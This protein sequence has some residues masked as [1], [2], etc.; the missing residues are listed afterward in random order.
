ML[1]SSTEAPVANLATTLVDPSKFGS[2]DSYSKHCHSTIL[3]VAPRGDRHQQPGAL[4]SGAL[5]TAAL[6]SMEI[7][8]RPHF[9]Q[10]RERHQVTEGYS[11]TKGK[12]P[13][14]HQLEFGVLGPKE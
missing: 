12:Y 6:S 4:L 9:W 2:T 10:I 13:L 1:I 7:T 14:N 3:S 11:T 8:L 5:P